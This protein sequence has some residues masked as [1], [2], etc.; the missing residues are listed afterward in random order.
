MEEILDGN[1]SPISLSQEIIQADGNG[2]LARSSLVVRNAEGTEVF[3]T[4]EHGIGNLVL[5]YK[6]ENSSFNNSPFEVKRELFFNPNKTELTKS[7]RLLHTVC[8]FAEQKDWNGQ[9][10]VTNAQRVLDEFKDCYKDLCGR[11]YV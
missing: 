7:R 9:S 11:F 6:D 3:S 10:I 8:V 2:Y 5:L 1:D 4:T